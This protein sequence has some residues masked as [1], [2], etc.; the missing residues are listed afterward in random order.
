MIKQ[1]IFAA[2]FLLMA[3]ASYAETCPTVKEIKN[4]S[5]SGWKAYDS[6]EGTPLSAAREARF[7]NM[8]EQFALAEWKR[9]KGLRSSIHCYYRD[10]SGSSLEAYLAKDNF[11][12]KITNKSF[13]YQVSG[14]MHCAAGANNCPFETRN[15]IQQQLARK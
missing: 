10:N 6:E 12:P 2:S 14:Y 7:E 8:A 3:G 5:L 11:I 13:W 4:H 15:L 1:F 9:E